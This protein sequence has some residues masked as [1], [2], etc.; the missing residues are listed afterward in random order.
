M[1]FNLEFG[2]IWREGTEDQ[3]ESSVR[4]TKG[5]FNVDCDRHC[6][7][8]HEVGKAGCGWGGPLAVTI[9]NPNPD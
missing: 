4:A 8:P 5:R 3:P 7:P 2:V 6:D 1:V 9:A